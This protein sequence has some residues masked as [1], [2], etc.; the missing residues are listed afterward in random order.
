M[1]K[2]ESNRWWEFYLVRYLLGSMVGAIISYLLC[3]HFTKQVG[4]PIE[5]GSFLEKITD[6]D[7]SANQIFFLGLGFV[8]C[9]ISSAPI[10][11]LHACRFSEESKIKFCDSVLLVIIIGV[12]FWCQKD[13]TTR[14]QPIALIVFIIIILWQF[15]KLRNSH[16]NYNTIIKN[17]NLTCQR[18][19]TEN[20]TGRKTYIETYK[21][22]R[23]HGNAFF[24]VI[25]EITL[26]LILYQ[27]ETPELLIACIFLWILPGAYIWQFGNFLET[28]L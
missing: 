5:I 12:T 20:Y 13:S 27:I 10:L 24:I 28:N 21:H 3:L 2:I 8:Y 7:K 19:L 18:E 26:G 22:L 16:N 1:Y 25:L 9:Y 17:K 6:V 23:E 4:I 14:Y 15:F 11:V